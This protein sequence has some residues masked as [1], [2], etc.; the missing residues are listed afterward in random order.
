MTRER[1]EEGKGE[2]GGKREGRDGGETEGRQ[3]EK[4]K[5]K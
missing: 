5:W 1:E 2:K 4:L 3:W